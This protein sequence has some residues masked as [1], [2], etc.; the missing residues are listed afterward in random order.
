MDENTAI[1]NLKIV[2]RVLDKYKVPFALIYGTA[3]GAYRNKG[4]IPHD[5]D[6]DIGITEH[7]DFKTKKDI[8]WILYG[9]GFKPAEIGFN[10]FGRFEQAEPG[11]NGDEK[12]GI[13]VCEKEGMEL[14][15]F[16]FYEDDCKTHGKEMT[17]IPKLGAVK[18]M[19][20]P[21]KFF[22]K[23]DTIKFYGDTYSIPGPIEEYLEF[24]YKDWKDPLGRDRGQ[25]Y[26]EMHPEHLEEIK[27]VINKNETCILKKYEKT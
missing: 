25:T 8:G 3:L 11:Y 24:T 1:K 2:K 20:I 23:L 7:I 14:S 13:I 9:L 12:T 19:S 15:I 4:F 18:L 6:I 10:V 5:N 16:F 27:D 22:K 17:C 21:S 26:F